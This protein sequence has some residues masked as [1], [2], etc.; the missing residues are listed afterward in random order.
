MPKWDIDPAGV[1]VVISRVGDVMT[2]LDEIIQA[3]GTDLEGA[4]TAAGTLA[5]GDTGGNA[6]V[7]GL[8]GAALVEFVE[9]TASELQFVGTRTSKSVN[10]AIQATLAYEA[11][12]LEM[13]AHVQHEAAGLV[14]A[15]LDMPGL[16]RGRL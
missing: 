3:Y 4:A 2:V 12:D 10:G 15:T 14:D 9:G 16:K 11:G 7:A 5:S 8:V 6:P 13:A 1:G